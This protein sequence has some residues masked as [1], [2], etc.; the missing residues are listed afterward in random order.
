M[1]YPDLVSPGSTNFGNLTDEQKTTWGRDLWRQTKE[2]SFMD[3][4][5][6]SGIN[7]MIQKVPYLTKS[8]KGTRAV[9]SLLAELDT[10]GIAGDS[11]LEGNE[12]AMKSYEMVIQIDQ[13]RNANRIAG[14]MADQKSIIN[15]RENSRDVLAYWL[16]DRMDQLAFLTM[17]GVGYGY[18][19]DGTAR[20][21]NGLSDL[22]FAADVTPPT[23]AF[24][25]T[26]GSALATSTFT[27]A[28]AH[29]IDA[30]GD[31]TASYQM[32]VELRA[33][34]RDLAIRGVKGEQGNELYHMFV[35][36]QVMKSLKLD[37][38]F[39]ANVRNAGVRGGA[40]PLFAGSASYLV[41]GVM[42]HEFR[43]TYHSATQARALFCGAQAMAFA[44]IGAPNWVEDNYDYQNQSGISV[45]KIFGM[46]K[47]VFKQ[48][49]TVS[50]APAD[51]LQDHGLMTVD[52]TQ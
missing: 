25:W 30:A 39:I 12:E 3:V 28:D 35:T 34:A 22:E 44:D 27:S 20:A 31:G 11:Q 21:A 2:N 6:G 45:S 52:L 42:I 23:R 43:H 5:T 41:D 32:I 13:L 15:F 26:A 17:S 47:S 33:K 37:T 36:P 10:D 48:G 29:T 4:F 7:S 40:N 46:K 14:R 18:K 38:D 9:I 49:P 8:E 51:L 24:A 19:N 50:G 1:A 16:A